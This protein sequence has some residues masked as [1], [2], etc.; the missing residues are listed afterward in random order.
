MS[1]KNEHF[2]NFILFLIVGGVVLAGAAYGLYLF[3]PYLVFYVLPFL[4]GSLLVGGI[5]RWVTMPNEGQGLI[6]H[7]SL[8]IAYPVLL[9]V[10]AAVFFADSQRAIVVDKGGNVTGGYYL[11]WPKANRMFNEERADTY[12][13][14]PFKSLKVK[15]SEGVVYD[16][17]EIGWIALW[18]LILGGPGFFWY[19]SRGDLSLV[20]SWIELRVNERTRDKNQQL[21]EKNEK[22]DAIIAS[23]VSALKTKVADL[24]KARELLVA[25]NRR[26][27]ATVEF[28]PDI[29]RKPEAHKSG[30]V[31]DSDI[32]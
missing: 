22:L 10:V 25:D 28:S 30:G 26:L 7:R 24:E 5:L 14:S 23:N 4:A 6:S 19:L 29:V 17:Q 15:A 9:L 21:Q 3:W 27:Q 32:L 1:E 12:L 18:C 2:E 16:R 13:G 11:D 31:L 20:A 8:A